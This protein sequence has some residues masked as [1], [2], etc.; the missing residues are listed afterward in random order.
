DTQNHTATNSYLPPNQTSSY[1]TT[2]KLPFSTTLPSLKQTTFEYDANWRKTFV[3]QAPNTPD[4][5]TSQSVY[6]EGAGN[7][8]H[9]TSTIDPRGN[10][11]R[12]GYDIR[13]RQ[14][15]TTDALNNTS[16]VV[17]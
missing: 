6:D 12:Y 10:T 2:S 5:A 3:R 14:I 15:S 11:T 1:I 17:F 9:L 13:D 16:S 4:T 7:V 8:G